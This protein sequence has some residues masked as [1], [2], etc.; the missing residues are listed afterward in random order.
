MAASDRVSFWYPPPM[1]DDLPASDRL[2]LLELVCTFA[3]ADLDVSPAERRFIERLVSQIPLS[4]EDKE[5][6][7]LW[8]HMAPAPRPM[9]FSRIPERYRRTFLEAARATMY[10]DGVL[11]PDEEEAFERLRGALGC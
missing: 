4:D 11:D 10:A 5:Q 1:L 3:W 2:L 7:E 8:T 6:V 9:D